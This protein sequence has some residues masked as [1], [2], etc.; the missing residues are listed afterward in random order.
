MLSVETP[1]F[2]AFQPPPQIKSLS[3]LLRGKILVD[4]RTERS[5]RNA[6]T[7]EMYLP[8][9]RSQVWGQVTNY[10]RWVEFFPD[11]VQS[12]VLAERVDKAHASK[13]IYQLG[14]KTFLMLAIEAEIY[15]QVTEFLQERVQFRFEQGTFS[16]FSADLTLQDHGQ[17]TVLTYAVQATPLIPVP[18]FMI[19]QL[20]RQDL[21]G[22]MAQMRRVL[23]A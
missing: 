18:G 19:E 9:R 5:G 14:R 22:N 8:L 6:V 13:R 20:L 12:R 10:P 23:C 3:P 16:D 15:L 11:I 17:G 21:P 1:H 7:A 2:A 4:T